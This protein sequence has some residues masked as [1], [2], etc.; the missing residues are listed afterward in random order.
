MSRL[1]LTVAALTVAAGMTVSC[2]SAP[3]VDP[4]LAASH[5]AAI[6]YSERL[7]YQRYYTLDPDAAP[8][9]QIRMLQAAIQH[10]RE[11]VDVS[12]AYAP[13]AST[14]E[15]ERFA[16]R[17]ARVQQDQIDAMVDLLDR[18]GGAETAEVIWQ[19]MMACEID[20]G[21]S[22]ALD[23][24]YL[25]GMLEHHELM[26]EMYRSWMASGS[27]TDFDFGLLLSRIGKGQQTEIAWLESALT[28]DFG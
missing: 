6:S 14:A 9:S 13:N 24:Q 7:M 3:Q 4:G 10:H 18:L 22:T 19:P 20:L 27:V 21:P 11:A 17:V 26:L 2:A 25:S 15:Y 23:Q 28:H 12:L 16:L 8:V 1:W 5:D